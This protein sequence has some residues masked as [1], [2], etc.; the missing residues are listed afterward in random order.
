MRK[1]EH[2]LKR[3]FPFATIEISRGNHYR[4]RLPNGRSVIV[5]ATPGDRRF[6]QHV[7]SD[8]RRAEEGKSCQT[9]K[10]SQP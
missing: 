3:A 1:P 9:R 7:R 8:V 2:E 10:E 6:M 4:I 5:S